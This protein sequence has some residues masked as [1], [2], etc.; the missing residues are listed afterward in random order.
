ML[1]SQDQC[2]FIQ[3]SP[4]SAL[5]NLLRISSFAIPS[6]TDTLLSL[7][8]DDGV[9][10]ILNIIC[11]VVRRSITNKEPGDSAREQAQILSRETLLLLE[12]LALTVPEELSM[13]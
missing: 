8:S 11:D 6:F 4:L 13:Q 3:S 10:Q 12:A 7:I 2:A 1:I 9:P 5:L